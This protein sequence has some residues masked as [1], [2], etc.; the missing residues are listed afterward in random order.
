MKVV[1]FLLAILVISCD[2][3]TV[4]NSGVEFNFTNNTGFVIKDFS[5]YGNYYGDLQIGESTGNIETD[6]Y[7]AYN[8]GFPIVN[9]SG[10]IQELK[11]QKLNG[12]CGTGINSY[13]NGKFDQSI[14]IIVKEDSTYY[15]SAK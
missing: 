8:K 10:E 1:S 12:I 13:Y 15:L 2:N 14:E 9:L 4:N 3:T 11:E 6:K 5:F 7:I